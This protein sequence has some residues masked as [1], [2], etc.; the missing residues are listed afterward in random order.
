[1]PDMFATLGAAMLLSQS[2]LMKLIR[3][4]PRR[5]KVYRIPK[6]AP[7]QFRV[8][9]QPA[10]EVKALQYWVIEN[11]LEQ[12]PVHPSATGY[13][14]G[15]NIADNAGPHVHSD[16]LLKLDFKDFFPSLKARD[17]QLL[18]DSSRI[19]FERDEIEALLQILFW[20]PKGTNDLRLSIGAPSSPLLSNILME[21]FD[22]TIA[23]TCARI[24]VVYTRY[25]DDLSFSARRS[26]TLQEIEQMVV[27]LCQSLRSPA[28]T[29]NPDKTARVSKRQSRRVTGL[30]LSNERTVSLGRER[31]RN[32]RAAVH[33]Y[34]N[35]GL[36]EQE[37]AKLTGDLAYVNSVEASFLARL[38]RRYG[39]DFVRRITEGR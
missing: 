18:A 19:A 37:R 2:E 28:L 31:K 14:K 26:S 39:A 22:R 24:G 11:V 36:S 27:A 29:I 32:L 16:F 20:K 7:N 4:A 13:R 17:F 38:S 34:F 10:R 25:A 15:L 1:M 35:R 3:S 33:N 9:A 12:F 21:G 6:R 30:V 8:I 23:A 5:Y